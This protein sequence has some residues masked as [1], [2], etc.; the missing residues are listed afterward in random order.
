MYD[1]AA[2]TMNL[3]SS[4]NTGETHIQNS[5]PPSLTLHGSQVSKPK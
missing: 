3:N 2:M 4:D 1:S 5:E